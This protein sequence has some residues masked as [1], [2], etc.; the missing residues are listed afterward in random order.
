MSTRSLLTPESYRDLINLHLKAPTDQDSGWGHLQNVL[1]TTDEASSG[2]GMDHIHHIETEPEQEIHEG[3]H[4]GI[5][6]GSG[7]LKTQI[8][9]KSLSTRVHGLAGASA[10]RAAL[11]LVYV[12]CFSRVWPGPPSVCSSCVLCSGL[13]SLLGCHASM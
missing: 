13:M 6:P 7:S 11:M 10:A 5:D 9:K 4:L 12:F 8:Q 2:N 3:R 1:G